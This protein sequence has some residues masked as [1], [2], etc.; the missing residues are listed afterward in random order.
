MEQRV[1]LHSQRPSP[2]AMFH[3]LS[4]PCA[5]QNYKALVSTVPQL[6]QPLAALIGAADLFQ[7]SHLSAEKSKIEKGSI[8]ALLPCNVCS[9]D[10]K[11]LM[12][13]ILQ[14]MFLPLQYLTF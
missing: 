2:L 1:L 6:P 14:F 3:D 13:E 8:G 5:V 12:V 11:H 9:H 10:E 4:Q 7:S